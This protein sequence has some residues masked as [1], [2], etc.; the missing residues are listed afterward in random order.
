MTEHGTVIESKGKFA[1]VRIER[2]SACGNCGKCGMTEN[3]KHVDFYVDNELNA[4][5][6]DTVELD[7][8]ETNTAR[9]AFIGYAL[10][11]IPALIFL[12]VS[13]VLHWTEWLT[14]LLFFVGLALGFVAV[15]LIDKKRK[16]KWAES[17]KMI[18]IINSELKKENKENE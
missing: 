1:L 17:P 13:L 7:I 3:Q 14:V 4:K 6:G 16:H 15:A 18:K 8:P 9:L 12:V 5:L 10:P 11:L 2:N